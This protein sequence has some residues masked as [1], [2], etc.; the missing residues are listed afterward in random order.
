MSKCIKLKISLLAQ[1]GIY[2]YKV[3]N[4]NDEYYNW[5]STEKPYAVYA[6]ANTYVNL[7]TT[8][9]TQIGSGADAALIY[10]HSDDA[11]FETY[12]KSEDPAVTSINTALIDTS[13]QLNATI[14]NT[15]NQLSNSISTTQNLANS[16]AQSVTGIQNELIKAL[17]IQS[18]MSVPT[19]NTAPGT[20]GDM[21]ID[22][23]TVYIAVANNKWGRLT[24]DFNF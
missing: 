8:A 18:G 22:G 7:F 12:K 16:T 6:F 17:K 11:W 23:D 2:T 15:A 21:V 4:S 10:Y 9:N 13:N 14:A 1:P 24:L 20:M 5:S 19:S 3:G